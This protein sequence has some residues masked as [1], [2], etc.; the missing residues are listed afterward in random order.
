MPRKLDEA[1]VD[2]RRYSPNTEAQLN[3]LA[4]RVFEN[5]EGEQFLNYLIGLTMNNPQQMGVSNEVL[6]HLEGQRWIVG[7]IRKRLQLS[8]EQQHGPDFSVKPEGQI[9]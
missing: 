1:S 4:S 6:Q 2:G 7:L 5:P 9:T 8:K 3:A